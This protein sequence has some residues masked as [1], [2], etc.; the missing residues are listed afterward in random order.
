MR[1]LYCRSLFII[2]ACVSFFIPQGKSQTF[3]PFATWNHAGVTGVYL[4]PASIADTRLK[5]D[6]TVFG[7]DINVANNFYGM[8]K[9]FIK[10]GDLFDNIDNYSTL[11][12]N[13]KNYQ[14]QMGL[15]LQLLNFMVTLSPKSALA[16]RKSVV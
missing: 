13:V 10:S 5:F 12:K 15:D 1:N 2:L 11:L 14:L 4:Q 7:L 6:M 3:T 16:D 8:K 9:G